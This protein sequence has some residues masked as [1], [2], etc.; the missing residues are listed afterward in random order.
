MSARPTVALATSAEDWDHDEDGP[1]LVD[2]L[3][4]AGVAG[5]PAVWTDEQVDWGR[6]DL[7]VVR[8]TWDYVDRREQFLSWAE[9]VES[10]TTLANPSRTL[11]W[12]TDKR[13]LAALAGA[14]VPV[15]PTLFVA[16]GDPLDELGSWLD[17]HDAVVVKPTVSAGSRDT[18]RHDAAD[19]GAAMEHVAALVAAGRTAMVQPYLAAVDDDGETGMVLFEGSFSHAF[20]KAALLR[21]GWAD[22]QGSFAQETIEAH[23]PGDDE[24]TVAEQVLE[25]TTSLLGSTPTYARVDVL[26]DDEGRPVLLELE[27]TEPSFFLAHSEGGATNAARCF[28]ALAGAVRARR[29]PRAGP[30]G[31]AP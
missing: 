18:A 17:R 8:S 16:P 28:A 15:V 5:E 23:V 27:L 20:S 4:A 10:V 29:R 1:L 6:F 31:N 21:D 30:A 24:L 26:R 9:A 14:G 2:A 3:G 12:N 13:Y 7:V 11:R 25:A 22:V 19:R